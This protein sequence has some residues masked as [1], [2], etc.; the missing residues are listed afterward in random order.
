MTNVTSKGFRELAAAVLN[1]S[2]VLAFEVGSE[3]KNLVCRL[4]LET[5]KRDYRLNNARKI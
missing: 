1:M 2:I 3:V 5:N 4:R